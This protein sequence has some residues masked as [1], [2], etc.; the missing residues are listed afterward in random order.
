[1]SNVDARTLH[2]KTSAVLDEVERGVSFWVECGR[3]TIARLGGNHVGSLAGA[4][5]GPR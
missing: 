3:R 4:N 5:A 1:M 2:N